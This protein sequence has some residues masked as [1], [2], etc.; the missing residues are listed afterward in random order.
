[1]QDL[2][3]PDYGVLILT[4]CNFLLLVFLLKKFAWNSI[5]HMLETRENQVAADKQQAQE[6]RV[7]AENIKKELDAKLAQIA[8]EATKRVSEAVKMGETQKEQLLAA[9][10]EQAEQ[11]LAQAKAQIEA[12]KNKALADVK[13]QIVSTALLAAAKVARQQI[14]PDSAKAAVEQVLNE[15]KAKH[16]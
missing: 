11:T 2:L 5:I 15:V 14:S 8:D 1:M 9:A 12:E 13:D 4:I 6:A 10:K 16:Q 7:A 3:K